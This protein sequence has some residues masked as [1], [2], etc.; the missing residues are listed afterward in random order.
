MREPLSKEPSRVS[1]F[2][3]QSLFSFTQMILCGTGCHRQQWASAKENQQLI[4]LCPLPAIFRG[5]SSKPSIPNGS[6][7]AKSD[8]GEFVWQ[9]VLGSFPG[10]AE[11]INALLRENLLI[12]STGR[13]NRASVLPPLLPS[14]PSFLLHSSF[15]LPVALSPVHMHFPFQ[16]KIMR[17]ICGFR[18]RCLPLTGQ[19][20]PQDPATIDENEEA[21]QCQWIPPGCQTGIKIPGIQRGSRFTPALQEEK[22]K[23]ETKTGNTCT[24][25]HPPSMQESDDKHSHLF[26]AVCNS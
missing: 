17:T 12:G 22:N 8:L 2:Y 21:G 4:G 5:L 11:E 25:A 20:D 23:G 19:S 18:A 6:Q 24:Q 7:Q 26:T 3:P 9:V 15:S 14:L 1:S 13:S 16:L 10:R